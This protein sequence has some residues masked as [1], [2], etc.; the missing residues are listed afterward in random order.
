VA[1]Q[2]QTIKG[3]LRDSVCNVKGS[4]EEVYRKYEIQVH[5]GR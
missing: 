4:Y 5:A 2:L 1:M 3:E